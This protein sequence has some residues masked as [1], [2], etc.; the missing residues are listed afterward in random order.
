VSQPMLSLPMSA[1]DDSNRSAV[2]KANP[3]RCQLAHG[4]PLRECL[5]VWRL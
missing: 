4:P 5:C 3:F 1:T 2:S